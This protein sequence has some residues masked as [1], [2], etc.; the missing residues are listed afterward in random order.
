M[1]PFHLFKPKTRKKEISRQQKMIE[2]E[3]ERQGV[4]AVASRLDTAK[5]QREFINEY[6]TGKLGY[7]PTTTENEEN[8]E[9]D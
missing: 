5:E 3:V 7:T 4:L 8:E 1:I 9:N 6:W 2:E